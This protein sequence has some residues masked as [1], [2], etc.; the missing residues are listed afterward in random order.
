MFTMAPGCYGSPRGFF[1]VFGGPAA[2][3]ETLRQGGPL[4]ASVSDIGG[5]EGSWASN[6]LTGGQKCPETM[7]ASHRYRSRRR[8]DPLSSSP[9]GQMSDSLASSDWVGARTPVSPIRV[10]N[11]SFIHLTNYQRVR[12][13]TRLKRR[14]HSKDRPSYLLAIWCW[15]VFLHRT[16]RDCRLNS[17]G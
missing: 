5:Q 1:S 3:S 8:D 17:N 7:S 10:G 16:F 9:H 6:F 14:G 2:H 15:R 11:E 13:G 12:D 4:T